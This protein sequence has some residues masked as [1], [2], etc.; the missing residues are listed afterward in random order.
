MTRGG[1][2]PPPAGEKKRKGG[3]GKKKGGVGEKKKGG[4]GAG[5]KLGKSKVLQRGW[6]NK[7]YRKGE[8]EKND[9]NI[10]AVILSSIIRGTIFWQRGTPF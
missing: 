10:F 9:S 6:K 1:K 5:I 8:E 7:Q 2:A 3:R 4:G